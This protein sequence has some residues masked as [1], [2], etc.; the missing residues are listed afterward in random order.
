MDRTTFLASLRVMFDNC[1]AYNKA[2]KTTYWLREPCK[3]LIQELAQ[4]APTLPATA[5]R[6]EFQEVLRKLKLVRL[7]GYIPY[8]DFERNP[9]HYYL[10]Y[11]QYVENPMGIQDARQGANSFE[12]WCRRMINVFDGA[13]VYHSNG[14]G[15]VFIHYEAEFL[16]EDFMQLSQQARTLLERGGS[17]SELTADPPTI[18]QEGV[19]VC[20]MNREKIPN[21]LKQR[22]KNV[23]ADFSGF[24]KSTKLF[25][26][27][28]RENQAN[29]FV[30]E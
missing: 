26:H 21:D 19:K 6:A 25:S 15:S 17:P 13:M 7:E 20:S 14:R 23:L 8:D 22:C 11:G 2:D 10:D 18:S 1:M 3:L 9:I 24:S 30:G 16:K 12:S 4:L 29:S 28:E 5:G 27:F